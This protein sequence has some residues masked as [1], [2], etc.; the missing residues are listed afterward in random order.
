MDAV[1]TLTAWL[2][3]AEDEVPWEVCCQGNGDTGEGASCEV[4]GYA[5][6]FTLRTPT[7]AL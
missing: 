7:P 5:V 3:T 1:G 6:L 4:E 2:A